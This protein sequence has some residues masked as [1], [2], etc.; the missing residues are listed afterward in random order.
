[1]TRRAA[2]A[3][4]MRVAHTLPS[5]SSRSRVHTVTRSARPASASLGREV[6][7]KISPAGRI[8]TA[9]STV[10]DSMSSAE[11]SSETRTTSEYPRARAALRSCR[12]RAS[13]N[14]LIR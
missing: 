6:P 11:P 13:K 1:M 5:A 8:A 2:R 12:A 3:S 7:A 10:C 14:G 9:S 4:S